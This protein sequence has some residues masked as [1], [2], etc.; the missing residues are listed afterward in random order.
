MTAWY[1]YPMNYSNGTSVTG[2]GSFFVYINTVLNNKLG[3]LIMLLA[4]IVPF[5]AL[6]ASSTDK[7]FAGASFF[8]FIVT[9]MLYRL[10]LIT[11]SILII[12]GILLVTAV[13]LARSEREK[14]GL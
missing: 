9:L 12:A 13:L 14:L 5:L 4:Y 2:L 1:E 11:F 7:A 8:G 3:I 10:H 6:K